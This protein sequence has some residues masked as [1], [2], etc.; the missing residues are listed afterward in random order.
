MLQYSPPRGMQSIV[1]W[2]W[3]SMTHAHN[4]EI[5]ATVLYCSCEVDGRL[6]CVQSLQ[7][8]SWLSKP[9]YDEVCVY[10]YCLRVYVA[11]ANQWGFARG[12]IMGESQQHNSDMYLVYTWVPHG[13]HLLQECISRPWGCGLLMRSFLLL[14]DIESVLSAGPCYLCCWTYGVLDECAVCVN[15]TMCVS[16]SS[17]LL[18]ACDVDSTLIWPHLEIRSLCVVSC[19]CAPCSGLPYN[20]LSIDFSVHMIAELCSLKEKLL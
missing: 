1:G 15:D 7:P 17:C 19:E 6:L 9:V 14:W 20:V 11:L 5:A 2:A 16:A 10:T 13:I 18:T 4:C 3:T 8:L 12:C